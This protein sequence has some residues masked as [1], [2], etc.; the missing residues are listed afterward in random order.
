M[1]R[2]VTDTNRGHLSSSRRNTG[3][4]GQPFPETRFVRNRANGCRGDQAHL[5]E[6][7]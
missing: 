1:E 3:Q 6:I 5:I 4:A 7:T 2:E